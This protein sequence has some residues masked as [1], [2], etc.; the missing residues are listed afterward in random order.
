MLNSTQINELFGIKESFELP[1]KLLETLFDN[2]LKNKL[3]DDFLKYDIDLTHD[4]LR[5]YF[6]EEHSNRNDLK[7][8][9]TPDCLCN[10][11]FQLAPQANNILDVCAGTGAISIN[12]LNSRNKINEY[13]LEELSARSI[14]VLLFN[15]II[16]NANAIV[17]HK[18]VL[19]KEINHIYKLTK[20]EK[21]SNIE[22]ISKIKENKFDLIVSNPPYSLIWEPKKDERFDD[23]ELAPKSKADYAFVLDILSRLS[24]TGK[25]FIVLPTGVLFRSG[26]EGAIRQK[27]IENNLIDT[28]IGLPDKLFLNTGIPVLILVLNKNKKDNNI[29]F[30][31]SDKN[32]QKGKKQNNLNDVNISKIVEAYKQ[33]GNVEKFSRL[34]TFEEIKNNDFNLNIP[35]YVFTTEE[36]KLKPISETLNEL[37]E[38]E[39][40]I[41]KITLELSKTI[42]EELVGTTIEAQKDLDELKLRYKIL[43]T[44]QNTNAMD[45]LCEEINN[46]SKNINM[47]CCN[48]KLK[49]LATIERAIKGKVYKKGCMILQISASQGQFIYL[50]KDSSVESKYAVIIPNP[51][52]NSKYLYFSIK[53]NLEKYLLKVQQDLNITLESISE[54]PVSFHI[55]KISQMKIAAI[56]ETIE[57]IE[58][59]SQTIE[60]LKKEEKKYLLKNMFC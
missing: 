30:I 57:K 37:I 24:D 33:R 15:L 47:N 35:R 52:I 49:Q 32:F 22:E 11:L 25:A 29:L 38:T 42:N 23:Y 27:L 8:D 2:E 9:Y 40:E 21:Y 17:Y 43:E 14:P 45:S 34:V 5:D 51:D 44:F 53:S 31:N 26:S 48:F 20:S 46:L 18:N 3:C 10:L 28:V 41:N 1:Q 50:D 19:T 36:E 7:Q 56:F 13:Q 16:R 6:Q 54:L 58:K 60:E 39:K 59:L 55:D 12:F 4:I